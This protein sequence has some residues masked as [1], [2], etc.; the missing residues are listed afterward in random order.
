MGIHLVFAEVRIVSAWEAV[1]TALA[2]GVPTILVFDFLASLFFWRALS[3]HYRANVPFPVK[4]FRFRYASFGRT[5]ARSHAFATYLLTFGI[6]AAGLH[7]APTI[8]IGF[9]H[10]TLLIPWT[11]LHFSAIPKSDMAELRMAKVTGN[12]IQISQSL[13]DYILRAAGFQPI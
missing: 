3:R 1:L 8:R 2:V 13:A 12:E 11:E 4:R 6:S 7:L 5:G 10:P 9:A